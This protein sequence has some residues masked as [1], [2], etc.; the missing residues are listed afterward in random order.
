MNRPRWVS[1]NALPTRGDAGGGSAHPAAQARGAGTSARKL[2][3]LLAS[4]K[5]L[6]CKLTPQGHPSVLSHFV[7][8]DDLFQPHDGD[9]ILL[10]LPNSTVVLTY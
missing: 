2:L 5:V 7:M 9:L 10:Y 3:M 6:I 1:G 4:L 8:S